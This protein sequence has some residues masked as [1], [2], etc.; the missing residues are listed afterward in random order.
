MQINPNQHAR[1]FTVT[2]A[3][4]LLLARHKIQHS[5]IMAAPSI[6]KH[7]LWRQSQT[8]TEVTMIAGKTGKHCM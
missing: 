7:G 5:I 6:F 2:F 3:V 8:K 1:H 4:E